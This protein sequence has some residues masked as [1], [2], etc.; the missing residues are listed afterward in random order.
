MTFVSTDLRP[1]T[2]PGMAEVL[3]I[4]DLGVVRS[5]A[6]DDHNVAVNGHEV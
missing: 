6:F 5:P 2:M 3:M 1:V 4:D